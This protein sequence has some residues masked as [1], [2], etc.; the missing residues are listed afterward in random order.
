MAWRRVGI[1]EHIFDERGITHQRQIPTCT[2]PIAGHAHV[3]VRHAVGLC[4]RRDSHTFFLKLLPSVEGRWRLVGSPWRVR[5]NQLVE[6]CFG[7]C[8]R[9]WVSFFERRL[10]PTQ[11][12]RVFR[13]TSWFVPLQ[14]AVARCSGTHSVDP[15]PHPLRLTHCTGASPATNLV[16]HAQHGRNIQHILPSLLRIWSNLLLYWSKPNQAW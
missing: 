2:C 12:F 11:A 13:P 3:L 9:I 1:E 6:G 5:N 10:M 15:S 8:R 14:S 4:G 16:T 7:T